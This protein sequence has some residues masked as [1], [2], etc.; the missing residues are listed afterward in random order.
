[1]QM[2][3]VVGGEIVAANGDDEVSRARLVNDHTRTEIGHVSASSREKE[4]AGDGGE[5]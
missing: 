5:E 3:R 1:M 2:H 4:A